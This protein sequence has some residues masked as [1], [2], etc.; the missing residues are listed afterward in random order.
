L[1]S[2][3]GF[4]QLF[5]TNHVLCASSSTQN[6]DSASCP[7]RCAQ[8]AGSPLKQLGVQL[9][10]ALA[11]QQLQYVHSVLKKCFE[12]RVCLIMRLS[13]LQRAEGKLQR[14]S[15]SLAMGVGAL[16]EAYSAS[17]GGTAAAA[18]AALDFREV[19]LTKLM[20][21]ERAVAGWEGGCEG[22]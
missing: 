15:T 11:A 18:A 16:C 12:N 5:D 2:A 7:D 14:R 6:N 1:I 20:R 21:K 9:D 22:G 4:Y 13:T 8:R 10:S 3:H 17:G 19:C